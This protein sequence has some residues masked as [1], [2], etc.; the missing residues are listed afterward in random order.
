MF[1]PKV[2]RA[3]LLAIWPILTF[4]P[5]NIEKNNKLVYRASDAVKHMTCGRIYL[6]HNQVNGN[7]C[8]IVVITMHFMQQSRRR[9]AITA[10]GSKC[11][12]ATRPM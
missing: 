5:D 6:H 9:S 1:W 12:D 4:E 10:G 11:M 3:E 7:L 2:E 8:I